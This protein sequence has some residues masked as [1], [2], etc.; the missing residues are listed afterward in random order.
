ML[1]SMLVSPFCNGKVRLAG[2]RSIKAELGRM[3]KSKPWLELPKRELLELVEDPAL[4]VK[5]HHC[6][7]VDH[8]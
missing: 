2:M 5:K 6:Q 3:V 8:I 4:K 1:F 7:S